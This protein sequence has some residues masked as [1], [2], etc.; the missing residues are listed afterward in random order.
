MA[1]K[2]FAPL[3]LCALIVV[4]ALPILTY[5]LGRDQGEFAT[6]AR[7]ILDGRIPYVD[8]W[9]PKPPAIFYVY[10]A[11]I[12]A[13]G[14][15]AEAVRAIDL[16][17]IPP[18]LLAL[19]W[20]GRRLMGSFGALV[21]MA[22]CALAYFTETFW[23]LTQND[24][25]VLLPMVLALVCAIKAL[26]GSRAGGWALASGLLCGVVI[27]FKYPFALFAAVV[28]LWLL[29]PFPLRWR[30]VFARRVLLFAAGV[31]AALASVGLYLASLGALDDL[32]ESARVT[33]GYTALSFTPAELIPSLLAALGY[34]WAHWGLLALL[35]FGG[36]LWLWRSFRARSA[37]QRRLWL[38]MSAWLAAGLAIMLV[39]A[40][41][42]DYH[43][44]PVLPPLA[45]LAGFPLSQ[46]VQNPPIFKRFFTRSP[47]DSDS[48]SVLQL[49]T[50]QSPWANITAQLV[51]QIVQL[52]TLI[53][54][55]GLLAGLLWGRALPYLTGAEDALAYARRFQGGE[56]VA[57]ESLQVVEFLRQRV[58]PGDSL[59]I[60]GFRPEVYYL[61][62]LNPAVRFIFQYP[63]VGAWYP[64]E[65]QQETVDILWAALPP[66][67]LVLQVDYMPWVTGSDDDSN[68][69]LQQYE[70]LNDWLIYNYAREAQIGNFLIWRR[71]P[72]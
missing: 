71:Q 63:L 2:R 55:V 21:A 45:L 5:P 32:I 29:E 43:W 52:A 40:K 69:L 36:A 44:L 70:E 56:F 4:A 18:M 72:S 27:W 25:I 68:T 3:I 42:Y 46:A 41:G 53:I 51:G 9:N 49:N 20:I 13:F 39:Q 57:D 15:T 35:A 61:S 37:A 16:I 14:R 7:G 58:V 19:G 60:W 10:A 59:Y 64:V 47:L 6:I 30:A 50:L 33:A 65:W 67:V 62:Q 34:R 24:G 23:T 22:L 12:A 38:L 17:L 26:D 1:V 11:A 8:L 31:A 66:Y 48:D 54:L 28:G